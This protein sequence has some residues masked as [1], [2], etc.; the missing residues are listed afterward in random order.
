MNQEA[1]LHAQNDR[2][3]IRVSTGIR[4]RFNALSS[5]FLGKSANIPSSATCAAISR[6]KDCL[7]RRAVHRFSDIHYKG[8]FFC[9]SNQDMLAAHHLNFPFTVQSQNRRRC[10][11]LHRLADIHEALSSDKNLFHH[12]R[13]DR[14]F[15]ATPA[16][17]KIEAKTMRLLR[18][19][20]AKIC[21]DG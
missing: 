12:S 13:G 8:A 2:T 18:P 1:S 20:R 17:S 4:T 6:R 11:D 9:Q 21:P 7:P 3:G 10:C 19:D 16:V 15:H 14:G 5:L